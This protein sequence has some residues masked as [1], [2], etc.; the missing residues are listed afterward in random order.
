MPAPV[1]PL[2][3]AVGDCLLSRVR[4]S[5]ALLQQPDPVRPVHPPVM[6][7]LHPFPERFTASDDTGGREP[8]G[9][10]Q[11][12]KVGVPRF[13]RLGWSSDEIE[14]GDDHVRVFEMRFGVG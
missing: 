13:D 11:V 3:K 8:V 10:P 4:E 12:L 2:P 5:C 9:S 1:L 7:W 6:I 14:T